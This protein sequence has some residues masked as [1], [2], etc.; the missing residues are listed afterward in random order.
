MTDR[1]TTGVRAAGLGRR[2]PVRHFPRAVPEPRSVCLYTP[3]VDA[4]GMGAHMVDLAAEF[5]GV[6][7]VSVMAWA[8]PG[9]RRLLARAEGVGATPL[10]L[11]HP[12]DPAFAGTVV[13]H[14]AVHPADVFH[15]HVGFGKE[16]FDGARAARRAGVPA[17]VQTQHLPWRIGSRKPRVRLFRALEPVDHVIMVSGAERR[18]YERIGLHPERITTVLNGVRPRG[19]GLGRERARAELGLDP[20]APVVLTVG[21][22]TVMKGQCHLVAAVPGLAAR[23]PG[24][25][26][27]F[28]GDGHLREA[29]ERQAADLDV[30]DS[31]RLAGHRPDAR[32]LLDAADVFV[33]PSVNEAMPLALLEAMEAGLPV[34]AT[35]VFG[36]A[37]IVIDR[38]TGLLVAPRDPDA[39]ESALAGLLADPE[40]RRRYAD[41]GRRRYREAFTS[42]RMAADTLAV[43]R[44]VLDRPATLGA[45]A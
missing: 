30:A 12:R 38:E 37:E 9:N 22:L 20:G 28:L 16:N 31:V 4:S 11:P 35:R 39:L 32:L 7:D 41:A 19:P 34:V 36:S 13:G 2:S 27:V 23:F 24:L 26:V 17:V 43:Y 29:L 5:A 25:Q 1:L 40:L 15:I 3:S 8:T 44:R 10:P 6:A 45:G 18:T 42:A 33:L 21:R 14:L